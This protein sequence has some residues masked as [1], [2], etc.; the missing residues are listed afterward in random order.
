MFGEVIRFLKTW[1]YSSLLKICA[2][3]IFFKIFPALVTAM[4]L[5]C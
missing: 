5:Y 1:N 3:E 2:P 4:K